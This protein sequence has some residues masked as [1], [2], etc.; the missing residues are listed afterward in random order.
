MKI[1]ASHLP[2]AFTLLA[3]LTLVTGDLF[4]Q[5]YHPRLTKITARHDVAQVLP[6]F[7][8][9]VAANHRWIA[10][11]EPRND[12]VAEDAGAVHVYDARTGRLRHRF[13]IPGGG[14][15]DYFGGSVALYDSWLAVGAEDFDEGNV[16]SGAVYVYDLTTGTLVHTLRPSGGNLAFSSLGT[17]VAINEHYVAAGAAGR[18]TGRGSV[19]VFDRVSGAQLF[20]LEAVDGSAGDVLGDS[21]ALSDHL[22]L[23]GAPG[24]DATVGGAY[25]FDAMRGTEIRKFANPDGG[26]ND[27]FGTMVG[28][29]GRRAI[30]G[31]EKGGDTDSGRVFTWDLVTMTQDLVIDCPESGGISFFGKCFAAEGSLLAVGA[32]GALGARGSSQG[33][34]YLFDLARGTFLQKLFPPD[35]SNSASFGG[36]ASNSD[37]G[38]SVAF[39]GNEL[40]VGAPQQDVGD[41][42]SAGAVYRF[43]NLAGPL[44]LDPI[45]GTRDFVPGVSDDAFYARFGDAA[46]NSNGEV[47]FSSALGGAGA[48]RGRRFAM[49]SDQFSRGYDTVAQSGVTPIGSGVPALF[50]QI[51]NN[52]QDLSLF[53]AFL[54]GPGVTPANRQVLLGYNGNTAA[55]PMLRTGDLEPV[56]GGVVRRIGEVAQ[57]RMEFQGQVACVDL[58]QGFNGVTASNDSG[59]LFINEG[60][61]ATEAIREGDASPLPGAEAYGFL[62]RVAFPGDYASFRAGLQSDPTTNQAIFRHQRGIGTTAIARKGDAAP[63]IDGAVFSTFLG[64]TGSEI[65]WTA[66][67]ATVRGGD[68][69]AVSN[70]GLWRQ[71]TSQVPELAVREGDPVPD[72][73]GNAVFARFVQ[74]SINP[75]GDILFLA[76]IRGTGI[77]A[78]NDCAVFLSKRGESLRILLREGEVAPGCDNARIG[79]IQRMALGHFGSYAVVTSLTRAP[80][81]RNQALWMGNYQ[82]SSEPELRRPFLQL[83]KGVL[84]SNLVSSITRTRSIQLSAIGFDRTGAGLKGLGSPLNSH[85][86]LALCLQF[87][88]RAKELMRGQP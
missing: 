23:A 11:G 83:R 58:V 25:L 82:N 8:N 84:H 13:T 41:V 26:V 19:F 72:L 30:I 4:A 27:L 33:A 55:V 78:A 73:D 80:R 74:F 67:R 47:V 48:S 76:K 49:V 43:E 36:T 32:E 9:A 87:D 52:Q 39:C 44:A 2:F 15:R 45:A 57:G 46:I 28:F 37:F 51:L 10:V 6:N 86:E 53:T 70:E 71:R 17:S 79:V 21:V 64:E 16:D 14:V 24:D 59:L 68:A 22:L 31:A 66:F 34:V 63:G 54:R 75:N 42:D 12:E 88:N 81:G 20:E 50:G 38:N 5:S 69:T 18:N 29:D 62:N 56:I 1:P 40:V 61:A 7:G 60:G 85:G 35:G 65:F 77:S 3:V